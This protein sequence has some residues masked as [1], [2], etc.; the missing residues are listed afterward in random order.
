MID[1]GYL[2][3]ERYRILDTLG[4]GGMA[5]VYLA[6]DIILQRKVAVKV[7]RLDLQKDP[8]IEARFQREALATSELS[9]PNI[10]SVLDV[11]ND[12][13]LPYM[14]MEYVNGPDLK[15]YIRDNSPLDLHEVIRIMNQ[16]LSAVALAHK[17]NVIHRDLKPQNILM[18]KR[19]N[20]K[21]ADF[22]I[23]VA[24]NQSSIT[25]TNSVMGSVHYMSPEQTRGGLVTKQ[26]DIYS[27][28][29][30]LYELITGK[31]PFNGDTPVAIALKHAQEP[32]PSIRKKDPDVPQALENVVLK[33]TAKDPRDRYA[34]AQEMK[35]DLDTSLDFSRKDEPPFVPNHGVNNDETIILPGFKP[36]ES[37]SEEKDEKKDL[38]SEEN[39]TKKNKA[40]EKPSFW[41][42][43]KNHKWWFVF[44]GIAAFLIVFIMI[45]AL[46]G[47]NN[48]ENK[49][50]VPDVTNLS[51]GTAK[52]KLEKAGLE[53]GEVIRKHSDSIDAGKV[54]ETK[55]SPGDSV[56][57]GRSVDIIISSGAGMT[58]VPDVVR[59]NYE[60]AADKLENL[61][62]DVIRENQYSMEIPEGQV[63]S[64]SIA[65]GVEVKP[66]QTTITL[67]VSQGKPPR[68][69][70]S[71]I[72]LKDL[73]NYSLKSAQDYAKEHGLTL[74]INQEYSE[75]VEKGMVI[76][77]QPKVGTRVERGST[78]TI[79]VS[80]GPKEEQKV[81]NITKTFT[82]D[83][84]APT[85]DE[86]D[87][88]D[89]KK[90]DEKSS[91]EGNHVQI[92]IKDDDHSLGNIY[93]DLY[94]KHDMSFSIPFSL[95]EGDGQ[96]RVVRDG[97]TILNEKV[98]K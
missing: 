34:S 15:D 14:V 93:R 27:L 18:D 72:T 12:Q 37:D 82:V 35:A 3:G 53:I 32:I 26:S 63:I 28:G 5:N 94:I 95:K 21:I 13:G 41:Q 58:K 57:K 83:Y 2:L 16:I 88:S 70:K 65:A 52:D 38:D 29:I 4:E 19:G 6:E 7:L 36:K 78:V 79:V 8:Q 10:I 96:L 71:L 46:S 89:N 80:K 60:L 76:S 69:K 54:I 67:V 87:D 86:N 20:V 24:L 97:Q 75:D 77:M 9:H 51:E 43:V 62:F 98:T 55:P 90:M 11:G 22:G 84:V 73:K 42:T 44:I 64:Q 50:R 25:Q 49:I 31:V 61:G 47:K 45:F 1:K 40:S 23:A 68:P 33:A 39:N 81:T 59:E 91:G 56:K 66:K 30:I 17:H 48:N 92:Y 85:K 74:Q